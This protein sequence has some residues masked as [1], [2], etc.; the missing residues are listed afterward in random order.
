MKQQ[1]TNTATLPAPLLTQ[2]EVAMMLGKS[3]SWLERARWAGTDAPKFRKIG[4]A[5]R[6]SLA[7]VEEWVDRQPLRSSTTETEKGE[8]K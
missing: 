1:E 7:E 3:E 6:Y 2:R 4:R 5:V 8:Q